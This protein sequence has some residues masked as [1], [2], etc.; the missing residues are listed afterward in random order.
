MPLSVEYGPAAP[1]GETRPRRAPGYDELI[2]I[3]YIDE[4]EVNTCSMCLKRAATKFGDRNFLGHRAYLADGERGDYL[5]QTF[6][7]VSA[8]VTNIGKGL[9]GLVKL[10]ATNAAAGVAQP[11]LGIYA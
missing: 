6:K 4:P 3:P 7:E 1:P 10:D 2:G 8:D 11:R 9:K 5:W